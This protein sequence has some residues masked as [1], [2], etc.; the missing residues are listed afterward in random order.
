M[1]HRPIGKFDGLLRRLVLAL[2]DQIYIGLGWPLSA[3]LFP[4]LFPA[5]EEIR[6]LG[7]I[8]LGLKILVHF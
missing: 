7:I 4:E 3:G 8:V 2:V 1:F 6:V 5:N